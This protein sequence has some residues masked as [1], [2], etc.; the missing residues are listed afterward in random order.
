MDTQK[1]LMKDK[2]PSEFRESEARMA[3]L[4]LFP[5]AAHLC[6]GALAGVLLGYLLGAAAWLWAGVVLTG[7]IGLLFSGLRLLRAA[8]R[9]F[10][11][12]LYFASAV[13]KGDL[14][15]R[16]ATAGS[17]FSPLSEHMNSMARSLVLVVKAFDRSSQELNSVTHETTANAL[18]GN[19]GVRQQ[20][21]LT[22]SSAASLEQLTVSLRVASEQANEAAGVAESALAVVSDGAAQ[23]RNLA[24]NVSG[25]ATTVAESSSIA[26]GLGLRSQEIGQIVAVIKD[27]AGQ[28]NL[29]ALN[30]AIEAAR[31][32]EQGRGFA[33]VADE[34]RKLAERSSQA[35]GEI[36]ELIGQI[37]PQIDAMVVMLLASNSQAA[38][39][40]QEG[41]AAAT[42]LGM[43]AD[44]SR[45]TVNL[46]RDIAAASIEQTTASQNIA[47]DIEHLAQ[48]ADRN[49]MLVRDS[50]DLSR[51]VDQLAVQL[52]TTL[53][54]YRYE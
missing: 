34:V 27:I 12:L 37:R 7:C 33:V 21:D 36:G 45:R 49:E 38:K 51:Y 16:M 26:S 23:V 25:L 47:S 15:Q 11:E 13:R 3:S 4:L 6:F 42:A 10:G 30:A 41:G 28:T 52:A 17:R 46:V 29:L 9:W 18:G 22:V 5:A 19:D 39:S 40:A 8:E 48:L 31:A 54:S 53:K 35:A 32:G 44:D 1:I 50:S 14:N 24:A 20:R 2:T 43:V